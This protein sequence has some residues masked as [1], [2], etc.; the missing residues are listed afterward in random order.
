[1]RGRLSIVAGVVATCFAA[2]AMAG[3][4]R[5]SPVTLE[6]GAGQKASTLTLRNDD[7][8]PM[9][10]QVR[11]FRWTQDGKGEALGPTLDVVASPPIAEIAPH[12]ERVIRIVR[13]AAPAQGEEGY[14]LIVDELPQPPSASAQQIQ[15]LMRQSIPLFFGAGPT[16]VA[17][18]DF[19]VQS[20]GEEIELHAR[21]TGRRRMRVSNLKLIDA[22]GE[23][24][25]IRKGLLG[26]VLAG[27]EMQWRAPGPKA[28]APQAQRLTA[29]TDTGPL[30]VALVP[31]P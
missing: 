7:D 18:V 28:G 3:A 6:F 12:S 19:S 5:V 10:F 8:T 31:A 25:L 15:L 26:Y 21:N 20:V 13:L 1:M 23:P 27:A 14:R 2:P 22:A 29:D 9:N 17:K 30:D 24:I 11:V 16:G 4:L